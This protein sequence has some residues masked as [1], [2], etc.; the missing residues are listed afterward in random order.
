MKKQRA[1][2]TVTANDEYSQTLMK[3]YENWMGGDCFQGSNIAEEEIPTGQKQGGGEAGE[4]NSAIGKLPAVEYDKS[5]AIPTGKV[6]N[7]DD[8]SKKDPKEKASAGDPP[9]ALKGTMTIGQGSL[10]TGKRQS[11]GAAI[12]DTT[13][14]ATEEKKAKKDYDGDGKVESGK[15]EY[16]G[17]RD[18]AIKKAM[19]KK[20]KEEF[21]SEAKMVCKKCG[22]NHP[23]QSCKA[24]NEEIESYLWS[25][26]ERIMTELSE[27]TETTFFVE[28]KPWDEF[29]EDERDELEEGKKKGLWDNIHAK[30]KRGEPPAKK[31]DKDYPKTLKVESMKQARKNVGASTC[32]DGYKAKGTKKKGGKVV[33]NCVK[34]GV[35]PNHDGEELK[36]Y[37]QWK[38]KARKT[39][40]KIMSYYRK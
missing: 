16:F 10:S 14:V 33:P 23:T 30:R 36:E 9:V 39:S 18:K 12:R 26:A 5:T 15:A 29:T 40:S 31:G 19:G 4:F 24:T 27:L 37:G 25:E 38:E 11:H 17:S 28:S 7:S 35:E 3:M 21:S 2:N 32:W 8:G 22:G 1:V 20:V 13:L 6:V 34:A